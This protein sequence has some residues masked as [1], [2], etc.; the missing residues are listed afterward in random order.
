MESIS[1]DLYPFSR[2]S[3]TRRRQK[4]KDWW[5]LSQPDSI[6][7]ARTREYTMYPLA[8]AQSL[9][10]VHLGWSRISQEC[11]RCLTKAAQNGYR[12]QT[13][14]LVVWEG[15]GS[16]KHFF[17]KELKQQGTCGGQLSSLQAPFVFLSVLLFREMIKDCFKTSSMASLRSWRDT[18]VF[19]AQQLENT[20]ADVNDIQY[21]VFGW[22][23]LQAGTALRS[24]VRVVMGNPPPWPAHV[25]GIAWSRDGGAL[26]LYPAKRTCWVPKGYSVRLDGAPSYVRWEDYCPGCQNQIIS[27]MSF[28]ISPQF[29]V[30]LTRGSAVHLHVNLLQAPFLAENRSIV[31]CLTAWLDGQTSELFCTVFE[32]V[33]TQQTVCGSCAP[34]WNHFVSFGCLVPM[35]H[36]ACF[37]C[38]SAQKTEREI[39]DTLR[40]L[41]L[42]FFLF[43]WKSEIVPPFLRCPM[44]ATWIERSW[45][46]LCRHGRGWQPTCSGTGPTRKGRSQ[47]AGAKRLWTF[48]GQYRH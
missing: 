16:L 33:T 17:L 38:L 40:V 4:W 39:L 41:L 9:R 28:I 7:A 46:S 6:W 19:S 29:V 14:L 45:I 43:A 42:L 26:G 22:A 3:I 31:F 47:A 12:V 37:E 13:A 34:T 1:I 2:K 48:T 5:H 36:L 10:V 11:W 20:G 25:M 23:W 30:F 27:Q 15:R 32:L 8:R 18:V 44:G 21:L 35:Q 24:L